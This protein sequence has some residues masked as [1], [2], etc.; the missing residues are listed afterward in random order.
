MGLEVSKNMVF[1]SY[2]MGDKLQSVT[3]DQA[4]RLTHLNIAFGIVKNGEISTADIESGLAYVKTLKE[5]NP[6]LDILLSLG[7]GDM[8]QK[9]PF[10]EAT[11]TLE[12]INKLT[13]SAMK[14]VRDY[15]LDGIDCDWEYPCSSG[16][17][18]E[19]Q[20][21]LILMKTLRTVLDDYAKER[22]RKC[23]L[24]YA[25]PCAETY[26]KNTAVKEL[27]EVADFMNLMCYDYRWESPVTGFHCNTYT[28]LGDKDPTSIAWA[29]EKYNEAGVPKEHLVLGAAFYSHRYDGVVGGGNG[30][31]QPYTGA[32]TY[33]PGYTS[34]YNE[35]EN[36]SKFT[37]YWDDTAKEAWLFD[38]SSFITYND[39]E[40][41]KY[42][43]ELVKREGLKGMMYWEHNADLTGTLFKAV[44]DNL[45][46]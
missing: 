20:Q 4:E 17:P 41:M 15:Q 30:Y 31:G 35:Y 34:I 26:I 12:G 2:C 43:A 19:K 46:S 28:P 9:F 32:Y 18:G 38:G 36:N 33:G 8:N 14:V 40:S 22:G 1:A 5:F 10:G 29:I 23:W 3:K 7:G 11:R 45:I 25:A 37:K 13:A 27:A 21:H 24:T 42:K 44:Y 6:D 39:P 16:D